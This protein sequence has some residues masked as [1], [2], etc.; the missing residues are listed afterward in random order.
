MLAALTLLIGGLAIC[1]LVS[2]AVE[3]ARVIA[4]TAITGA[5]VAGLCAGG[6]FATPELTRAEWADQARLTA[7]SWMP[8]KAEE[9]VD[10]R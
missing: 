6:W 7:T 9:V 4:R 8:A 3:W 2:L 1:M 10:A 5:I